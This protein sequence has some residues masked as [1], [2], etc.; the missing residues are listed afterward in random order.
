MLA[1]LCLILSSRTLAGQQV[2]HDFCVF[3]NLNLDSHL[4][5][6]P[7]VFL[8]EMGIS[9]GDTIWHRDSMAS[10]WQKRLSGL[11]LFNFVGVQIDSNTINIHVL[12]RIYTWLM[13]RFSW[14]DRNFNVWWQTRDPSRLIYGGTLYANNL[15]GQ[16]YSAYLTLV[17]GYNHLAE[18]GLNTPF[19][20]HSGG[21][22]GSFH[23]QYWS[24]HE[25]WNTAR[26]DTLQ[27]LHLDG[28]SIQRNTTVEFTAKHRMNYFQ[29]LE[30]S[31]GYYRISLDS[32]VALETVGYL[33]NPLKQTEMSCK[34]EWIQDRRNQR[35]YPSRG[36]LFRIGCKES[37]FPIA[38]AKPKFVSTAFVRYSHFQPLHS[39]GRWV[40]ATLAA[41]NWLSAKMP[42][43]YSRQLGYQSD[44]VRGYE[45]LVGD[46]RGF[47]L[48]KAALRYAVLSNHTVGKNTKGIFG[49][50][51]QIPISLW[52]NIFADAGRVI[53]PYN[54]AVNPLS[55]GWYRGLGLGLDV[56]VWYSAM[57]RIEYSRNHMGNGVFN[58]S[59]KNAF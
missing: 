46:G 15:G 5:T 49:N 33:F 39:A 37:L 55:G 17:A 8:R 2:Q 59:F 30:I 53:Q 16:N 38:L 44:Y 40:L 1:L 54:E 45:P 4:R 31:M 29:R 35:D 43:R 10:V 26:H 36:S 52:C 58:V 11:N 9:F 24:N 50:Y 18:L 28:R 47:V 21:W 32:A 6:R 56:T 22:A 57:A 12:E 27:F 20:K 25:L 41:G 51:F 3:K 14:A 48:G 34:A 23:M 42:Y 19:T 13:P 7:A